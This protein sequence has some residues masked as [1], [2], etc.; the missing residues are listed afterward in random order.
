MKSQGKVKNRAHKKRVSKATSMTL[1]LGLF[2]ALLSIG[3]PFA[4]QK[5]EAAVMPMSEM[6]SCSDTAESNEAIREATS[7]KFNDIVN[8]MEWINKRETYCVTVD[9]GDTGRYVAIG[10]VPN[11]QRLIV[12]NVLVL[13]LDNGY[14]MVIRPDTVARVQEGLPLDVAYQEGLPNPMYR[15]EDPIITLA[16]GDMLL[17]DNIFATI[18]QKIGSIFGGSIT[19]PPSKNDIEGSLRYISPRDYSSKLNTVATIMK[20][21]GPLIRNLPEGQCLIQDEGCEYGGNYFFSHDMLDDLLDMSPADIRK[22]LAERTGPRFQDVQISIALLL[23]VKGTPIERSMP[24]DTSNLITQDSILFSGIEDPR[25]GLR[26]FG[27]LTYHLSVVMMTVNGWFADWTTTILSFISWDWIEDSGLFLLLD[28]SIAQLVLAIIGSV[29]LVRLLVMVFKVVT[30]NAS[31]RAWAGLIGAFIVFMIIAAAAISP[32]WIQNT[33]KYTISISNT[34]AAQMTSEMIVESTGSI[35]DV[36]G[37]DPTTKCIYRLPVLDTWSNYQFAK[38]ISNEDMTMSEEDLETLDAPRVDDVQISNWGYYAASMMDRNDSNVYRAVDHLVAP[39]I[40]IEDGK[41]N[42]D[43][44]FTNKEDPGV[45][46]DWG[47]LLAGLVANM[48]IFEVWLMSLIQ[49][50]V[51]IELALILGLFVVMALKG[52]VDSDIPHPFKMFGWALTRNFVWPVVTA[53]VMGT[54]LAAS[55]QGTMVLLAA[56]I[57]LF[58]VLFLA[59][60]PL[61]RSN[62]MPFAQSI[63]QTEFGRK[64]SAKLRATGRR[65]MMRAKMRMAVRR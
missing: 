38:G 18:G 58:S 26:P 17:E 4:P 20:N 45:I 51:F 33:G 1:L 27:S 49:L 54:M 16:I 22:N 31:S 13:F 35:K 7:L 55:A 56:Q 40:N 37:Q 60:K 23:K 53:F 57:V 48:L 43:N 59:R 63:G 44:P 2:S 10:N 12:N 8:L 34:L 19:S 6:Y 15:G 32:A 46:Q 11:L 29:F 14:A 25:L 47:G 52:W 30:G 62:M 39:T 9:I 3:S 28:N 21:G 24:I 61:M 64:T 42:K 50:L 65:M 5:A 36:C 41:I